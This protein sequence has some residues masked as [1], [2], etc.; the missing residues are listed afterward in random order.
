MSQQVLIVPA[1]EIRNIGE[2]GDVNVGGK[3]RILDTHAVNGG[4]LVYLNFECNNLYE[5]RGV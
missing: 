2:H 4:R 1:S 5:I 3:N